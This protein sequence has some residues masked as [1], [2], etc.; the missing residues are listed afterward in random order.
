MKKKLNLYILV[1]WA[2]HVV[3]WLLP[4]VKAPDVEPVA[5]W[6]AFRLATCGVLPCE[7]IQFDT[8]YH[9]VFA[10][11]SVVTTLFFLGSPWIVL[12]GPRSVRQWSAWVAAGAF[13]FNTYWIL[14]L[15]LRGPNS[16]LDTTYGGFRFSRWRL[17][18]SFPETPF[19]KLAFRRGDFNERRDFGR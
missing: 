13:I 6:K 5:G 1:A 3:S 12:S 14:T 2:L 11:V 8:V 10:T 16:P 4:A 9:A 17:G 19:G 15:G 18:C 7:G